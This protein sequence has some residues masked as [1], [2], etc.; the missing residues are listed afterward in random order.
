MFKFMRSVKL[1]KLYIDKDKG[2]WSKLKN[3]STYNPTVNNASLETFMNMV[4]S[5]RER[6]LQA[7]MVPKRNYLTFEERKAFSGLQRH[8]VIT[9]KKADKGGSIVIL[10][11]ADY[12]FVQHTPLS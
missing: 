2:V 3:H 12:L 6:N 8:S 7:H 4:Y 10:N 9:I 5:D 11:N 1:K